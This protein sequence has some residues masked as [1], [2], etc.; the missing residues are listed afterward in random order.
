MDIF[1]KFATDPNLELEGTWKAIGPATRTK[2]DGSPDPDS[3][4]QILVAR[5]GNKRHGRI[6]SRL[7]KSN[8]TV[9]DGQDDMAEQKGEEITIDAMSQSILLGWKNLSFKGEKLPDG[10]DRATAKK[11]LA[12]KDFRALVTRHAEDFKNFSV[13]QED[14]DAKN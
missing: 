3:A 11:L 8:Q 7:Y 13:T 1:A 5:S 12:V 4:P 9:L 6:I 10:Y 14:A 2:D